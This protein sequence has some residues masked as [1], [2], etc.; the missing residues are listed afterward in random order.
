MSIRDTIVQ[1]VREW[2]KTVLSLTDEDV[3]V[4]EDPGKGPK[5]ALP[6]ATVQVTA[7][8]LPVSGDDVRYSFDGGGAAQ[9]QTYGNRE[10]TVAID[11][12]GTGADDWPG[13]LQLALTAGADFSDLDAAGFSLNAL[14]GPTN[15]NALIDTGYERRTRLELRAYYR[16]NTEAVPVTEAE[17]FNYTATYTGSAPAD[18]TTTTTV[19]AT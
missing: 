7:L 17:T 2:M 15:V 1:G 11:C 19:D 10:A 6:F 3:I 8:G 4:A 16:V 13:M 18:F 12:Y 9:R 14:S 5:P